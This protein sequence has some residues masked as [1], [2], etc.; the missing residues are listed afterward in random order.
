MMVSVESGSGLERRMRVQVPAESIEKEIESRLHSIGKKAK[1][2][3]FRPGKA[4]LHVIRKQYGPQVR[5]EVLSEMIQSSYSEAVGQEKLRPAGGPRIEAGALE[6]GK[7]LEYTAIFEV[8]PE[9]EI[10]GLDKISIERPQA[11]ITEADVDDMIAKLQ[12]QKATWESVERAAAKPDR[13]RIDFEGR[14]DG[15]VFEGGT[16]K[17]APVELGAGKML[18][19][20]EAGLAGI[21][22]GEERQ[23]EVR[24]PDDYHA[25]E[26]VGKNAVFAVKAHSVEAQILP[27]L[28][29]AFC[30]A[31]GVDE[32]GIDTLRKEVRANMD[33]ELADAVRAKVKTQL[34]DGLLAQNTLD[35]PKSL[36]EEEIN[37]MQKEMFG[38]ELSDEKRAEL[39]RKPFEEQAKRRIALGLMLGEVVRSQSLAADQDRVRKKVLDMAG[40]YGEPEQVVRAYMSNPSLLRQ[41]ENMTLE[42]QAVDWLLANTRISDKA[43][44]FKEAMDAA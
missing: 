39:P 19:D 5:K 31:F 2:K 41:V 26:L 37:V 1:L 17:D 20:F 30:K 11:D 9:F 29:E 13:V 35:V 18:K 43:T 23:I 14:I 3:G 24:F 21:L 6:Q 34:M 8:Y 28:D 27:E 7:D 40:S 4:P 12:R 22:A 33:R 44:T 36:I 42:E 32:G 10:Q 15:E 16:A 25:P 38:G